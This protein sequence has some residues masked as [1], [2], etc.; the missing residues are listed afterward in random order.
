YYTKAAD[1]T[2][3]SGKVIW[4]NVH[5]QTPG[6][7]GDLSGLDPANTGFFIIPNGG[8]NAGLVNGSNVT[9]EL[10]AGQWQA[11]L[12]GVALVGADGAN[13]LFSNASLN[14]GGS[15]LQDTGSAGNQNWED[16][17]LHSDYDYNDVSTNVT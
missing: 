14:P 3:L 5:N 2:P 12:G 15:H 4:A 7:V 17:T 10:V 1:G 11:K 9:F 6:D 8:A 13:V 16:Q